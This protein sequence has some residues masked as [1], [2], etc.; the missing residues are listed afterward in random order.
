M[1]KGNVEMYLMKYFHISFRI[2]SPEILL[3]ESCD[4]NFCSKLKCIHGKSHD[5]TEAFEF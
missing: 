1:D 4:I 3:H 5:C 2:L